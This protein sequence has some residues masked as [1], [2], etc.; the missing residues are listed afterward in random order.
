MERRRS[1]EIERT[2]GNIERLNGLTASRDVQ[3]V[4]N[5]IDCETVWRLIHHARRPWQLMKRTGRRV[6]RVT[7]HRFLVDVRG[8]RV[9]AIAGKAN[10]EGPRPDVNGEPGIALSDPDRRSSV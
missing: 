4:A 3:E 1:D 9:P 7:R 8:I 6:D 5:G 10:E 2:A